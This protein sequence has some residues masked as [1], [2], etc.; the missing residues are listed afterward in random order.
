MS[1]EELLLTY[2]RT[3]APAAQQQVLQFTQALQAQHPSD[4]ASSPDW[5]APSHLEIQS[6]QQLNALLQEGLESLEQGAGIEATDE[7]WEQERS[8]LIRRLAQD[9]QQ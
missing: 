1:Q 7:W 5:S 4:T 9:S 2:W 3:L 6:P 8:H